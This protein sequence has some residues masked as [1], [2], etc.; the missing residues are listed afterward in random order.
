MQTTQQNNIRFT[1]YH[2]APADFFAEVIDGLQQTPKAISPKFFYD[3][4]GSRLF[5]AICDLDEYYPT[6]TEMEILTSHAGEI[7]DIIGQSSFMIEPGSGSS[8]KVRLLLDELKPHTYMPMDISRQHLLKAAQLLA[9]EY[10]WLEIHAACADFTTRLEIPDEPDV[11]KKVAFFPGSSIGNFD[12]RAA[13]AFLAH[14]GENVGTGGGLLI[15][16]DL[17]KDPHML[18]AAYND[19]DGI[20]ADFNLNLLTRINRELQADFVLENFEHNAFYN[21]QL[22]RI[23]MHLVSRI[24]QRVEVGQHTFSF[25]QGETIHTESSYKYTVNDFRALA[26]AAGFRPVK[27]WTDPDSLFSVHYFEFQG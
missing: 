27:L 6:R 15:G 9:N 22:G 14:L 24:N 19:S 12:P 4:Q 13:Q 17:E 21:Q 18:H 8:T 20:T 16:V 23:E 26:T 11:T 1:D 3:A 10:P 2:P 25:S 5:D 7:A